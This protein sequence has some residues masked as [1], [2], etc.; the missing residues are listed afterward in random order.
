MSKVFNYVRSNQARFYLYARLAGGILLIVFLAGYFEQRDTLAFKLLVSAT[1]INLLMTIFWGTIFG[2]REFEKTV[3]KTL[4]IVDWAIIFILVFPIEYANY[5]FSFLPAIVL[6]STLFLIPRRELIPILTTF[7]FVFTISNIVFAFIDFIEKP[8]TT[9]AANFLILGLVTVVSFIL[10]KAVEELEAK[11]KEILR[12]HKLLNQ[13][14]HKLEKELLVNKQY[15]DS[16]SRNVRK[17]DIEIKNI[18]T[19]SGQINVRNDSKKILTSFLLTAIGQ[20]G[21][22]HAVIMTRRRKEYNYL[23]IYV[24]K[25][26]R[27]IDL[28]KIRIYFHSNLIQVLT[29]IREPLPVKQIPRD[30]LYTDEINLLSYFGE[31]L[32]CPIFVQSNL[33]GVFLIGPKLSGTAFNKEDINLIAILTNQMSFV[34]EQAQMTYEYQDFYAKTL[35]A[36]LHSLEAKYMYARGHNIRTANYVNVLSRKMGF[37]AQDIKDFSYG[38]LLH[39]IG[40][41]AIKDE[42]LLNSAQ[43][44]DDESD[45]KEKILQH[46]IQGSKILK[47]AGFNEKIIDMALHHHEF[48]NGN[49]FPNKIGYD[50]LFLGTRILS[51]CNAY[52]AMVS[53]RPHRKA[54]HENTAREYLNYYAGTQFDPEIVKIFLDELDNNPDMK[55]VKGL[56]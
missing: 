38:A 37:S 50:D 33:A 46:T 48:Y 25:G 44:T 2:H 30:G 22:T 11:Q 12:A 19:L 7:F 13:K 49:G 26:L 10:L 4:V 55:K 31:D 39:D 18:L 32:I 28:S 6:I 14:Y 8:L 24:Q 17:K 1:V 36:M 27:G 9:Y 40:K 52:D 41:I 51:V 54:L 47:T 16:L 15:V 42:Y 45:L 43:L 20:I 35:R 3:V 56:N 34:L 29:S 5:L 21:S 53:D 23:D